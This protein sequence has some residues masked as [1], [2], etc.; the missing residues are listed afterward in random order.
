MLCWD[1][2]IR[3]IIWYARVFSNLSKST[4]VLK[5]EKINTET[6]HCY[7]FNDHD[8]DKHV[9]PS[10]EKLEEALFQLFCSANKTEYI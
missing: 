6:V 9:L 3:S 5:K 1:I 2:I 8:K 10:Y 7:K 4:N